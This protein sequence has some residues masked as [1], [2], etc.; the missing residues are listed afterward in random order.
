MQDYMREHLA[1]EAERLLKDDVLREAIER[2]RVDALEILAKADAFDHT[3]VLKAQ[4]RVRSAD[5]LL[6]TLY[7]FVINGPQ[8]DEE[9]DGTV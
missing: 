1:K 9:D 4:S 2:M 5:E 7:G 3:A 6:E 8:S